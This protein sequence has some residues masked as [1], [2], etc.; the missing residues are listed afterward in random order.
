MTQIVIPKGSKVCKTNSDSV[1]RYG[2]TPRF[3]DLEDWLS[4]L[5]VMFEA[6]QYGGKDHNRGCI[7]HLLSLLTGEAK[8][9]YHRHMVNINHRQ[10]D[11]TFEQ[12]ILG[13][14]DQFIHPS[15]MRDVRKAFF[16]IQGFYDSLVDHA[17]NMA[18][19]P[20]YLVIE[21]FL[22]GLPTS[23]CEPMIKDGLSPEINTI[24]DFVAE[25]KKHETA[26]KTL[27]YYN[28]MTTTRLSSP[29]PR[30]TNPQA[31]TRRPIRHKVGVTLI[32]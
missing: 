27:N 32:K 20:D 11:W 21:I 30:V 2:R 25:A 31:G 6:K 10:P 29:I 14:Y 28:H 5:V 1:S 9:W 12:V 7:L 3:S 18:I 4:N 17:Q 22:Q 16:T 13:L 8:K 19:Y 15:T 23:L 26:R 24:N